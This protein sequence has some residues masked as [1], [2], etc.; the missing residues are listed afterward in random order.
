MSQP[1]IENCPRIYF[2][3]KLF[4]FFNLIVIYILHGKCFLKKVETP[5]SNISFRLRIFPE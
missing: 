5:L 3:G 1:L 4:K 2:P